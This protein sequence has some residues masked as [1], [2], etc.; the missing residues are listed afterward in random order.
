MQEWF[1]FNSLVI[2][3]QTLI[4][5]WNKQNLCVYKGFTRSYNCWDG[6]IH[7]NVQKNLSDV[8][9]LWQNIYRLWL[10]H[11]GTTP[12]IYYLLYAQSKFIKINKRNH[13]F[14][15]TTFILNIHIY[16][17]LYR[18]ILYIHMHIYYTHRS[19]LNNKSTTHFKEKLS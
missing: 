8:C 15:Y 2:H 9:Y 6:D 1:I 12:S 10:R 7:T 13:L 5:I 18:Y 4:E 3:C 16:T 17:N 11:F 19:C 14:L